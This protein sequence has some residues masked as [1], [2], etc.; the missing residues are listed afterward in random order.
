MPLK[1]SV[2]EIVLKN[3]ARGLLINAP[4]TTSVRYDIQ[5]RAGNEY[6]RDK[7]VSQTAHIL[8]H[9]SFGQNEQFDSL[10]DFSRE[11]S[12][13]GAYHNAFTSMVNM[14]YNV[15]AARME[16]KRILDLQLLAITKPRFT[17]PSLDAEKGNVREEIIGYANNHSRILWQ[18][19]MRKAG[20]DR[21]YDADE[22]ATIDNVKLSDI[23]K[24]YKDTHTTR[25]MR[26]IFSGDLSEQ[27]EEIIAAL[28]NLSLPE[29]EQ[30]PIKKS[31]AH[32]TGPVH[33]YRQDLPSL[34]FNI[35]FFLN[36]E[37]SRRELRAMNV[38]NDIIT[39]TFHSRIWGE[40][41]SRGICYG[42]G[43]WIDSDPSNITEW[44]L[45][46]QVS[47]EN[48][49]EL[50][51][52]IATELNNI[53]EH[54]ITE[55][56]LRESKDSRLGAMQMGTDT[57]RSLAGW[58]GNEY[59]DNNRIDY[60]EQMPALI[61]GTTAEEIQGLVKEFLDSDAW[62]FGGIGKIDEDDFTAHYNAFAEQLNKG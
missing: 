7:S 26:F 54:G 59:Y 3:G 6:V 51:D 31:K 53:A 33:I 38:L 20:L 17:Q 40:A 14:I 13:N 50:F 48:A 21:W 4:D 47:V 23:E 32:A 37:L 43:S 30:L 25:N 8:E 57:V 16:W 24:H 15:D 19:V 22:L 56:E 2:E 58:Y 35:V 60:V 18:T 28:E 49:R 42:M 27:R 44:G 1:H 52:L 29:G 12:K 11:F 46:G 34:A 5:F 10:E 55:T 45:G 39:D 61:E 36:R 41:R 9:M 62:S